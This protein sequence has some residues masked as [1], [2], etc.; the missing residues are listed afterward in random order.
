M[1]ALADMYEG[2]AQS[3]DIDP[4]N[5]VRCLGWADGMRL[6]VEAVGLDFEPPLKVTGEPDSLLMFVARRISTND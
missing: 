6:L 1:A 5:M 2:W 3:S 4:F